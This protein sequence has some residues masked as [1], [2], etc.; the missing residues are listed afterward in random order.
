MGQG[1]GNVVKAEE[2]AFHKESS[3]RD[4]ENL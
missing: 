3:T 2:E 4:T 1:W